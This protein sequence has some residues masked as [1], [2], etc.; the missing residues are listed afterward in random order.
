[1]LAAYTIDKMMSHPTWF[2]YMSM[3]SVGSN[4]HILSESIAMDETK[5]ERCEYWVRY[6][7][8]ATPKYKSA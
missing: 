1:L 7:K 4:G 3:I 8:L 2:S 5:Q 6:T